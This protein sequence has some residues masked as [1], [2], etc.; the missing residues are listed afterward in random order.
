MK[1]RIFKKSGVGWKRMAPKT[2]LL[3][4]E[5][6]YGREEVRRKPKKTECEDLQ[7][8]YDPMAIAFFEQYQ[9]ISLDKY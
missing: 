9:I 6:R 7:K 8:T 1:S 5:D 3:Q 2:C 4:A